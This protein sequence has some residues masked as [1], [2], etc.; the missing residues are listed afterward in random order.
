MAVH[1]AAR[2]MLRTR[3]GGGL[4]TWSVNLVPQNGHH[5]SGGF[6]ARYHV[7]LGHV[8]TSMFQGPV[9]AEAGIHAQPVGSSSMTELQGAL[10]V[11]RERLGVSVAALLGSLEEI[12]VEL[13]EAQLC[14]FVPVLNCSR[15]LEIAVEALVL[16]EESAVA[17]SE[18][19]HRC[20][21]C[22]ELRKRQARCECGLKP[23][24]VKRKSSISKTN[25]TKQT[26]PQTRPRATAAS[27]RRATANKTRGVF[28]KM[29]GEAVKKIGVPR[30]LSSGVTF[31]LVALFLQVA[32]FCETSA[33]L[34]GYFESSKS[35]CPL[36][37]DLLR[38]MQHCRCGARPGDFLRGRRG[39]GQKRLADG[40]VQ[41]AAAHA[42]KWA[43]PD[44]AKIARD[45]DL[46]NS[47]I[48]FPDDEVCE[49]DDS[50][51][52]DLE[53]SRRHAEAQK[54]AA[55]KRRRLARERKE[56]SG[57]TAATAIVL[58]YDEKPGPWLSTA[59]A[60]TTAPLQREADTSLQ[61]P[62][63]PPPRVCGSPNTA[64]KI[65]PVPRVAPAAYPSPWLGRRD[66]TELD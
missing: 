15:D 52:Y 22:D 38:A 41:D 47:R 18:A 5:T 6:F 62:P 4:K 63:S 29:F 19:S 23:P 26:V 48:D 7:H 24:R 51:S 2:P 36:R 21:E 45:T 32:S 33:D 16:A 10:D 8:Y 25:P 28:E 37:D 34:R 53:A 64:V 42:R 40:S 13:N 35:P 11:T 54:E 27:R 56:T 58:D 65:R 50:P 61:S 55:R 39:D 44:I 17:A 59:R 46:A 66:D 30:S 31:R 57:L 43:P 49:E 12:E 20:D 60:K 3:C 1:I 9:G 14:V